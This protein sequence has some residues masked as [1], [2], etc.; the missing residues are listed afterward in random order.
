MN[1]EVSLDV[2]E[3]DD[4]AIGDFLTN[5]SIFVPGFDVVANG[6]GALLHKLEQVTLLIEFGHC[7][8]G[9]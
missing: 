3:R 4:V 2:A 8:G 7:F 6:F 9:F 1:V 5:R